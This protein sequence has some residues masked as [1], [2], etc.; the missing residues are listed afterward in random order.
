[1][2][3]VWW[4]DLITVGLGVIQTAA[5]VVVVMVAVTDAGDSCF[6]FYKHDFVSLSLLTIL[7]FVFIAFD[8]PRNTAVKK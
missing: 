7:S 4:N 2:D 3:L 1:M 6:V 5:I 8:P